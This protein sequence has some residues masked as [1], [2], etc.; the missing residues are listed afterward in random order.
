MAVE[1]SLT[2][3][4]GV[5]SH[6]LCSSFHGQSLEAGFLPNGGISPMNAASIPQT[7][8][9]QPFALPVHMQSLYIKAVKIM[10]L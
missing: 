1:F 6:L 8:V 2:L 5:T 7:G 10:E 4:V 3:K 9:H